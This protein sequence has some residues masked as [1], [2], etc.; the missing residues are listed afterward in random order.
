MYLLRKWDYETQTYLPY[1]SPA[2]FLVLYSEDMNLKMDCAA[3]GKRCIYGMMY[4]SK[5]I[6]NDSGICFWVCETCYRKELKDEEKYR[7]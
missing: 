2:N 7:K 5:T 3:C 4:T 1:V 6:H